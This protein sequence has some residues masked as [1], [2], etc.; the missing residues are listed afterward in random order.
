MIVN[1]LKYPWLAVAAVVGWSSDGDNYHQYPPPAN[2]NSD[3]N[4]ACELT[5]PPQPSSSSSSPLEGDW[6]SLEGRETIAAARAELKQHGAVAF[7]GFLTQAAV[8]GAEEEMRSREDD[9]FTTN[10][11]HTPYL[12]HP[13]TENYPP[14]SIYNHYTKTIVAST[15]YDELPE[16][17]VLKELYT[18][19][20]LLKMVSSIFS[21]DDDDQDENV[22][23]TST[24]N[25]TTKTTRRR[26][27]H[28]SE[29]PLGCCSVNVFRPGYYHG[30]PL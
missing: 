24:T 2:N 14:H 9:A 6:S 20:R 18:D 4:H 27:L 25:R 17:S 13:D 16:D 21:E 7:P 12:K 5:T 28:L 30:F 29:D 8:T 23:A 11:E 19:P 3:N 1:E 10:T 15:A 22:A 26:R